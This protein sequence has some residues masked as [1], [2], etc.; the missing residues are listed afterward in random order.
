MSDSGGMSII[1]PYRPNP[2]NGVGAMQGMAQFAMSQEELAKRQGEAALA[3]AT[4]QYLARMMGLPEGVD[5]GKIQE[6]NGES[7]RQEAFRGQE[8]RAK[9][10]E[11]R[12]QGQETRAKTQET[13]AQA[14]ETRAKGD[15]A[16]EH[17]TRRYLAR[18]MGLPEG[19]DPGKIQHSNGESQ[20]QGVVRGQ[21]TRAQGQETR[22][23]A[24]ET[25]AQ[26]Q[27][28]RVQGD[29][30]LAQATRRYLSQV[31]GLPEG[32][33][34]IAVRQSN[35]ELQRQGAFQGQETRAQG[36]YDR[37]GADRQSALNY[38]DQLPEQKDPALEAFRKAGGV[39]GAKE[40]AALMGSDYTNK[41]ALD[42][43]HRMNLDDN[44]AKASQETNRLMQQNGFDLEKEKR[45][46]LLRDEENKRSQAAADMLV[47]DRNPVGVIG[48]NPNLAGTPTVGDKV[49]Q[50]H[51]RQDEAKAVKDNEEDKSRY[52]PKPGDTGDF[53][54]D[55]RLPQA[56]INQQFPN[57]QPIDIVR[58]TI[59]NT[60]HLGGDRVW[61]D[62]RTKYPELYD[63]AWR[64]RQEELREQKVQ[65]LLEY[66]RKPPVP[67]NPKSVHGL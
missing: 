8:T 12:A 66:I 37:T 41:G 44:I 39:F 22:A 47:Y 42:T 36:E 53:Q 4:R 31:M 21:E 55:P 52:R 59:L 29:A 58:Q 64:Q 24:Q 34:P 27:E 2:T 19:V 5:P 38:V 13:R 25:R 46:K 48:M 26:G 18:V 40:L 56:R 54:E 43:R 49:D 10:Q 20:R 23:Q 61:K 50:Y 65:T 6:Y 3:Q 11:T 33:D 30:A 57:M 9:T 35:G 7:Q 63:E 17:A 28:T 51:N 62:V 16:L 1:D 15:A 32:V 45:S 67:P 60:E 14:Q